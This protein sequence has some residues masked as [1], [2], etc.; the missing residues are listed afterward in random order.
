MRYLTALALIVG[1]A[2]IQDDLPREDLLAAAIKA[3][4]NDEATAKEAMKELVDM[5]VLPGTKVT[6][7]TGPMGCLSARTEN[8]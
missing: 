1:A 5:T 3:L 4:R 6:L 2:A 8:C 7:H